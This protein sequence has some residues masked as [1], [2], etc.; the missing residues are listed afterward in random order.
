WYLDMSH[1]V[2][3]GVSRVAV[4]DG[5]CLCVQHELCG[6][7]LLSQIATLPELRR[8]GRAQRL[9]RAVCARLTGE[10]VRLLCEDALVGF[11]ENVGFVRSGAFS[12]LSPRM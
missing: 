2:R 11:Y 9:I 7:A 12:I 8:Q 5:S 1:R 6:E 10:Q 3:H 4:L